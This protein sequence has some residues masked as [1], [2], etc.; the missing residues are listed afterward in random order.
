MSWLSAAG[1]PAWLPHSPPD[2][3]GYR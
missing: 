1:L 2:D 3:V